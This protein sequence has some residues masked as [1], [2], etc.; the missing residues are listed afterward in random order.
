MGRVPPH[1][2]PHR[3]LGLLLLLWRG[4]RKGFLTK[5]FNFEISKRTAPATLRFLPLT[6]T[7]F[8]SIKSTTMAPR[9]SCGWIFLSLSK[10]WMIPPL[11]YS[12]NTGSRFLCLCAVGLQ[13]LHICGQRPQPPPLRGCQYTGA[14]IYMP[15]YRWT[16]FFIIF[17]FFP[18][19]TFLE[20]CPQKTIEYMSDKII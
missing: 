10:Y 15:I 6:G 9:A 11:Y 17:C 16:R 18:C 3:Q 2:Q 4:F 19:L 5:S 7:F 8:P 12:I 1:L 20:K 14:N 13:A